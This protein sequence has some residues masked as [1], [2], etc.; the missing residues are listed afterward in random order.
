MSTDRRVISRY[1]PH[2]ATKMNNLLYYKVCK[3]R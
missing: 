3:T 2:A 1:T